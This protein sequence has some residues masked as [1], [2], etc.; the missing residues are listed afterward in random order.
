MAILTGSGGLI[1]G[2]QDRRTLRW[3]H[4]MSREP[5][6]I[7]GAGQTP[8]R[9]KNPDLSAGELVKIAVDQALVPRSSAV[10]FEVS[11]G[12]M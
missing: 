2:Q 12:S 1:R 8:Y 7:V 10:V 3:W 9:R 4:K 5:I 11:I 6:G